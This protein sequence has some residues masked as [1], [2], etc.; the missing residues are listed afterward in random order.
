[1][2][3]PT[4]RLAALTWGA[5]GA[6][7]ASAVVLGKARGFSFHFTSLALTRFCIV[8][9]APLGFALYGRLRREMSWLVA[10]FHCFAQFAAFSGAALLLQFPL[11]SF[12]FPFVDGTLARIEEALGRN[13]RTEFMAVF[14]H[15]ALFSVMTST[16]QLLLWQV[17]VAC[18]IVGLRDPR[19][20]QMFA[21]A[22]TIA[23]AI[24]L[25]LS[26]LLPAGSA[27]YYYGCPLPAVSVPQ[28]L[29]LRDGS[30]RV[31]DPD[32]MSGIITFPSYHTILALLVG[33]VLAG[34]GEIFAVAV[35]LEAAILVSTRIV[36]GHYYA[37][38]VAGAVIAA[39]AIWITRRLDE[40]V[41]GPM[42]L[43]AVLARQ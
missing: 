40:R 20:L 22:N 34:V 42:R 14:D 12:D 7:L 26:A 21:T 10:P 38:M 43:G 27:F 37:D 23:L 25:V 3:T 31:L 4:S 1:M 36:G 33:W 8:V 6:A 24:T 39:A 9:V 2:N 32:V 16:Y 29:A 15:P 35:T 17:P 18:A 5:V 28:I 11:A 13:W 41:H 30:L 19:R